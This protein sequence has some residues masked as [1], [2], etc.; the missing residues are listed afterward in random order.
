VIRPEDEF[1]RK[2]DPIL[3]EASH[4]SALDRINTSADPNSP[5]LQIIGVDYP[6][7][8]C[9]LYQKA[10][11]ARQEHKPARVIELWKQAQADGFSPGAP[12]EYFLFLDAFTGLGQWDEATNLSLEAVHKF[13]I[14]RPPMCDY[15]N[16]LPATPDRDSAFHKLESKLDCF[17]SQP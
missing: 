1:F 2:L 10:D 4:L 7:D 5:F 12:F 13:P 3:R 15:W 11:L 14:V 9:N 17:G 6:E 16:A 8:W